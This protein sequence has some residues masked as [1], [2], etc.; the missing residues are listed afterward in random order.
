[1]S[2]I[3]SFTAFYN[4]RSQ[5]P[6]YNDNMNKYLCVLT[7]IFAWGNIC[8][9]I[10]KVLETAEFSGS[11]QLYFLGLPL[12]IGMIIFDKDERIGLLLRNINNF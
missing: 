3:L 9:F 6:Y 5:W 12:I 11:L 10:A 1:M 2:L 8:V 4:F 7:G